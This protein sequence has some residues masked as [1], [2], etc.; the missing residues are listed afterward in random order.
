MP[1]GSPTIWKG[2][3]RDKRMLLEVAR[4][5]LWL[6]AERRE[7]L[8][9]LPE[10]ERLREPAGAFV[11]LRR[12][13]RLR[14]C[15]GQLPSGEALVR[16]V[17]YCAKGAAL[18]DPRFEPVSADEVP[19]LEVEVSVI[20]PLEEIAPERIEAGKHG[21]VISSGWLRG[22]LLPQVAAEHG[23]TAERFLEETCAKAGLERNAWKDPATRIQAFTAEVFSESD[24]EPQA[25]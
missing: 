16:V 5:A 10:G 8:E 14:G 21:L 3:N 22:V 17:A 11:T 6:A 2:T 12:R 15:I 4:R 25:E 7:T 18:E 24:F 9:D 1:A 19:G 20:S 23:W 13:G